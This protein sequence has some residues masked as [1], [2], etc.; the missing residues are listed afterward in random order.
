MS[1]P[2][3]LEWVHVSA[4]SIPGIVSALEYWDT[5]IAH[6]TTKMLLGHLV[7][8]SAYHGDDD[9]LD[10]PTVLPEVKTRI[11]NSRRIQSEQLKEYAFRHMPEEDVIKASVTHRLMPN[12]LPATRSSGMSTWMQ[13]ARQRV[14]DQMVIMNEEMEGKAFEGEPLLFSEKRFT[15]LVFGFMPPRMLCSPDGIMMTTLLH[16]YESI[17][18][19]RKRE[20]PRIRVRSLSEVTSQCP[21]RS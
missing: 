1:P 6:K 9:I 2:R 19:E 18:G 17:L 7:A 5:Q 11:L 4:T 10:S 20:G 8:T 12:P 15:R 3:V 16:T 21:Q 13:E 14:L